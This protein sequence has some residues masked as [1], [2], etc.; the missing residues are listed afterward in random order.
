MEAP[1]DIVLTDSLSRK[2][3]ARTEESSS[4]KEEE[5][6]GNGYAIP[7]E[8]SGLNY[9]LFTSGKKSLSLYTNETEIYG[10]VHTN[11]SFYYQGTKLLIQG[12]LE[13]SESVELRTSSGEDACRVSEKKEQADV[14][15]MPDFTEKLSAY[16]REGGKLYQ[17]DKTFNSGRVVMDQSCFI[18]GQAE[19]NSTSFQG[20]G[21]VYATGSVN[22]HVG[23]IST[24][25]SSM[26]FLASEKE[27]ITLNGS[28]INMNAV[29][30]APNGC[31]TVNANEFH[32][33]GRILAKEVC[34]NG[35]KI[36]IRAGEHDYDMLAG[37]KL[38]GEIKKIYD[39]AEDFESDTAEF[40]RTQTEEAFQAGNITITEKFSE[41][42]GIFSLNISGGSPRMK[43]LTVKNG[44]AYAVSGDLLTWKDAEKACE[45]MGGHL[46]V[47]E[48]GEEND[49]ICRLINSENKGWYT[50]FG[51]TDEK[52]EGRW[53]KSIP[54]CI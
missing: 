51:Y 48:S 49:F 45:E 41:K 27:N 6:N 21:I 53:L 46:A 36:E 39:S 30:Y 43:D 35:T 28:D 29:L 5:E 9:A 15:E 47:I 54:S 10:D 44:H 40:S 18:D 42:T 26:I 11:Q 8:W 37:M 23:D 17:K 7:D 33:K 20:Q 13:A 12:R 14:L 3:S 16:V 4:E 25:G 50:A 38:S 24:P 22:Y 52:N 31:V 1:E 34:I 19:F 32:L 2:N